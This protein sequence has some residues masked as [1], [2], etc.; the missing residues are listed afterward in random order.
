MDHFQCSFTKRSWFNSAVPSRTA[1]GI[2]DACRDAAEEFTRDSACL[3]Q[4][5]M[6]FVRDSSV[7]SIV[8]E[9]RV[10][11]DA[12]SK[13]Y[14]SEF[15]GD[16]EAKPMNRQA[17]LQGHDR[18]SDYGAVTYAQAAKSHAAAFFTS[19]LFF[20][21]VEVRD[22]STPEDIRTI[23]VRQVITYAC[24]LRDEACNRD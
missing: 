16:T 4:S 3:S 12:Q 1:R 7:P 24:T 17:R 22:E 9:V 23:P 20:V 14:R 10:G 5:Q 8:Y 11:Y 18:W 19:P 13:R 21:T 2:A 6:V 15:L